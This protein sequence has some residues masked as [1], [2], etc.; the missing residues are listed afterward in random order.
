MQV[1]SPSPAIG[2]LEVVPSL[3]GIQ[4]KVYDEATVLVARRVTGEEEVP[5]GVVALLS[6]RFPRHP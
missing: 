1:I 3:H 5:V 6:G 2:R 4:D